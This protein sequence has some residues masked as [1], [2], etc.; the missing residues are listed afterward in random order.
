MHGPGE[1]IYGAPSLHAVPCCL[2]CSQ[3]VF[4]ACC[5]TGYIDDR[6]HPNP[7][8]LR[9]CLWMDPLTGRIEND[10]IWLLF[11]LI[12]Y[13]QNVTTDKIA[14]VQTI[15]T[16]IASCG[17]YRFFYDLNSGHMSC[18]RRKNLGDCPCSAVEVKNH[19]ILRLSD[20]ITRRLVQDFRPS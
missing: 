9:H 19:F 16:G 14:V 13:F 3:I 10:H 18:D 17:L 1:K 7:Q 12:Y 20:I 4:Q 6:V 2:Q 11:Q 5:F 8:Y 15:L